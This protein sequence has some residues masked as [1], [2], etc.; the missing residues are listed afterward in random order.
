MVIVEE[1]TGKLK[2][3]A[4]IT[5]RQIGNKDGAAGFTIVEVRDATQ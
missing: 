3:H 4:L 5:Q 2:D 1:A